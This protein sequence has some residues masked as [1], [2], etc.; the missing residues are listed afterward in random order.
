MRGGR[1]ALRDVSLHVGVNE[2][3]AIVGANGA[4]K[5][6]LLETVCGVHSPISGQ[7]SLRGESIV[8][9]RVEH[10]ARELE[11]TPRF[12]FSE[13]ERAALVARVRIR[14]DD[15][16]ERLHAGTPAFVSIPRKSAAPA[17][18]ASAP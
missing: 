17:P 14:I 9:A 16:R 5:T 18:S 13:R 15:A 4:G 1:Q 6:T 11:F 8:G 10:I 2:L 7:I 12:V 3:V